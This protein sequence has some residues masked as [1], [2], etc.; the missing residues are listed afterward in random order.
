M[1][2]CA[3][4]KAKLLADSDNTFR[5]KT[6]ERTYELPDSTIAGI[7]YQVKMIRHYHVSNKLAWPLLIQTAEFFKE[8]TTTIGFRK[9][10]SP[11]QEISRDEVQRAREIQ[12]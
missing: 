1:T 10:R 9:D 5:R 8:S 7:T 4:L 3:G 11:L 12:I 2:I 6:F